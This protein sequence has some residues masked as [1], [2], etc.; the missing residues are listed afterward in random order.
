M[1]QR[2][3]TFGM[4]IFTLLVVGGVAVAAVKFQDRIKEWGSKIGIGEFL[5]S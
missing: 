1:A 3:K 2:K 5:N 4:N